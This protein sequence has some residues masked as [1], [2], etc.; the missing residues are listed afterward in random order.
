[1]AEV[2]ITVR[3]SSSSTHRPERATVHLSVEVEEAT[4]DAAYRGASRTATEISEHVERLCDA[5]RGPVTQWSSDQVRVWSDRPWDK[6]GRQQQEVHHAGVD[7]RVSFSDFDALARWLDVVVPMAGVT[8]G[9]LGWSLTDERLAELGEAARA[10]AV[11]DARDRAQSYA[12]SLGLGEVRASAIADPGMLD[13][14][15]AAS[16]GAQPHIMYASQAGMPAGASR[17]S[18]TPDQI[19]VGC[20]VDARFVVGAATGEGTTPEPDRAR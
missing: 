8:L 16:G 14:T 6:N 10:A 18:F 2:V 20:A 5:E 4:K 12:R 17:L 11:R 15:G 3:G 9:G 7:F 19:T 1:M 13:G